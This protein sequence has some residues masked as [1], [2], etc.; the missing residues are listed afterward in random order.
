MSD[1][2]I[3]AVAA[4]AFLILTIEKKK[5]RYWV[6]PSLARRRDY[7]LSDLMEDLKRDDLNPDTNER[8]EEAFSYFKN[9]TRMSPEDFDYLQEAI[10]QYVEKQVT[11]FRP[12]ISVAEQLGVTLRFLATGDSYRSLSY[13]SSISHVSISRFI[14]K[15]CQA[16]IKVLYEEIKVSFLTTTQ[17]I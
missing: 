16:L 1:E 9:F 2:D 4:A 17:C 7:N 13:L 12:P 8:N 3:A 11:R 14:P 10:A 15:V 6:R 5:R